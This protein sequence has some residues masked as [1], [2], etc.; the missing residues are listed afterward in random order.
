[1]LLTLH[2]RQEFKRQ[3]EKCVAKFFPCFNG[4][5][6]VTNYHPEV[7]THT[8]DMSNSPNTF[9]TYHT[10]KLKWHHANDVILF[11][12]RELSHPGPILTPDGLEEFHMQE[13]IDACKWGHSFQ[14]LVYW[15]SYGPEHDHWL[16]GWD[17]E[18]CEA[19]DK[20]LE[21]SGSAAQ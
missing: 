6:E 12:S 13:I 4:P 14:Y 9:P 21:V 18:E 8:L 1:M 15:T 10:S 3:G 17:L 20:W 2:R 16:V 7:S 5:Y 11:P 19:L